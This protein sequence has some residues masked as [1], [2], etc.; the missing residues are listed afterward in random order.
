MRAFILSPE[1]DIF[2]ARYASF[3][4][5][6]SR[7]LFYPY[8]SSRAS[9]DPVIKMS[10]VGPGATGDGAFVAF[11]TYPIIELRVK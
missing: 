10:Y 5:D 11:G 3:V 8:A 9:H 6:A 4:P 7:R 1:P 2:D